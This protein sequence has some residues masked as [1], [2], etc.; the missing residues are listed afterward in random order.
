MLE[1]PQLFLLLFLLGVAF[2]LLVLWKAPAGD[3]LCV[4]YVTTPSVDVAREIARSLVEQRLV[5]CCNILGTVNSIYEW[6]G[7]VEDSQEQ[8]MMCKSRRSKF[9]AIAKQIAKMHPY[10]VPEIIATPISASSGPYG[11]WVRVQTA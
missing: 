4:V 9:E 10:D 3:D 6:Q 1:W 2:R 11:D 8:L 5:A 7:N